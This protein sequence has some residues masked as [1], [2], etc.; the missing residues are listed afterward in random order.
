VDWKLE[1][2]TIPVSDMDRAKTFYAEQIGF[3]VDI[4]DQVTEDV[5]FLQLTPPGSAC[6][7]HLG[8]GT[9]QLKPGSLEGLFLV[10]SDVRAA[11]EDLVKRGV[12]VGETLVFDS[13]E[14][15]PSRKGESLDLVG[16]VFFSDPDGN[17]WTV[18]QIPP[19]E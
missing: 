12:D 1:V 19:R 11:R 2:V 8:P 6:S 5:R 16:V 13:G 4:D 9:E 7:I 3:K 10:V 18:Q 17:R 15:R 14:Y